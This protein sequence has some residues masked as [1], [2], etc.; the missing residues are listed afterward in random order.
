MKSGISAVR[1]RAQRRASRTRHELLDAALKMFT[2]KGVDATTIENITETADVGKG[3]FYRHFASKQVVVSA[4]TKEIFGDL[5]EKI[6]SPKSQPANLKDALEHLMN[7]HTSF[8]ADKA[9]EFFVLLQSRLMFQ[10]QRSPVADLD[11][12]LTAYLTEIEKFLAPHLPTGEMSPAKARRLSCALMGFIRAAPSFDII[13]MPKDKAEAGI[14]VLKQAFAEG[15]ADFLK[16]GVRSAA[17]AAPDAE[18]SKGAN[19]GC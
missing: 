14:T 12:P 9:S 15:A 19:G 8:F 11:Q 13:E 6:R 3:T 2:E 18:A 16:R 4:L 1:P 10:L 17:T 5:T 7:V